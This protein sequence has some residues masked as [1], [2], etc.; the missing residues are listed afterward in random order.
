MMRNI[1]EARFSKP[2]RF[3]P[4]QRDPNLLCEYHGTHG[5]GTGGML[6]SARGGGDVVEEQPSQ[7]IVERPGQ[8]QLQ[9]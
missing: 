5:H 1:K 4:S 9:P 6:A 3:D 7:I 2:I 8:E